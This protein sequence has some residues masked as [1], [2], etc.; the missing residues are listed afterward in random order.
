M[1]TVLPGVRASINLTSVFTGESP[2]PN[3]IYQETTVNGMA[4]NA[5][6][7]LVWGSKGKV[8]D[9]VN[10]RWESDHLA[11]LLQD[12]RRVGQIFID[13]PP[14]AT[15][16][17]IILVDSTALAAAP[18]IGATPGIGPQPVGLLQLQFVAGSEP[19]EY[20]TTVVVNGGSGSTFWTQ[21]FV[22]AIP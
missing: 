22:T 11:R 6:S 1:L 7:F 18:V 10:L 20:V 19:G 9:N 8:L 5:W 2:P 14:G 21:A 13:G 3:T 16:Q 17:D 4:P 15:G 12:G